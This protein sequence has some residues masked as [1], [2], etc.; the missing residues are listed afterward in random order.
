MRCIGSDSGTHDWTSLLGNIPVRMY[1]MQLSLR[2]TMYSSNKISGTYVLL[3]EPKS[4]YVLHI[5]H[6]KKTGQKRY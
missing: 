5:S 3:T 1:H 2:Q 4:I 6:P